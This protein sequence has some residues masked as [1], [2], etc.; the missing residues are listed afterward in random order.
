MIFNRLANGYVENM[1]KRK[2]RRPDETSESGHFC[3]LFAFKDR[4]KN[5][6]FVNGNETVIQLAS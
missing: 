5:F 1:P 6:F 4:Q 2:H 3:S